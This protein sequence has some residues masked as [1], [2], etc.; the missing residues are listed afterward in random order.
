MDFFTLS[1]F[2]AEIPPTM[3]PSLDAQSFMMP[4]YDMSKHHSPPLQQPQ[5]AN[6]VCYQFDNGLT[7]PYMPSVPT[8]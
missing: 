7:P 8:Y 6:F 3:C 4:H 2:D 1:T 5:D